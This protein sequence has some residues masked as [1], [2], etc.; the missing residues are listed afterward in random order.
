MDIVRQVQSSSAI[1]PMFFRKLAPAYQIVKVSHSGNNVTIT[2]IQESEDNEQTFTCKHAMNF[3]FTVAFFGLFTKTMLT[4][5]YDDFFEYEDDYET[6]VRVNTSATSTTPLTDHPTFDWTKNSDH[7]YRFRKNIPALPEPFGWE[8]P[9]TLFESHP[10]LQSHS[11]L[12]VAD[13]P[14]LLTMVQLLC[15]E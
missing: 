6:E 9:H 8:C 14:N 3:K 5:P 1:F 4:D 15:G 2:R 13:F 12:C 11:V 10:E 7:I